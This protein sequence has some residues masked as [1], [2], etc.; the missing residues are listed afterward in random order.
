MKLRLT[1]Q[2]LHQCFRCDSLSINTDLHRWTMLWISKANQSDQKWEA[3]KDYLSKRTLSLRWMTQTEARNLN[4]FFVFYN[5]T[6]T[7]NKY[8]L[9]EANAQLFEA[10]DSN[11]LCVKTTIYW[12]PCSNTAKSF[13]SFW[14]VKVKYR[15][16]SQAIVL[17]LKS[18]SFKNRPM[19]QKVNKKS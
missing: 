14:F 16:Q 19:Q 1:I 5:K 4:F 12:F 8:L 3:I 9:F 2:R 7:R 6:N 17:L 11:T 10:M 15:T 13:H 18:K